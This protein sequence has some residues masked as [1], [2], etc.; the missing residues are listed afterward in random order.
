MKIHPE[1]PTIGALLGRETPR[2]NGACDASDPAVTVVSDAPFGRGTRAGRAPT[3][4]G[5]VG[6]GT[7]VTA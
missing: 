1:T 4:A 3:V 6:E 5:G 7:G 2:A